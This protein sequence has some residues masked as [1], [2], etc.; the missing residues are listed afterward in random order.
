MK[1]SALPRAHPW[2]AVASSSCQSGLQPRGMT[3][4]GPSA[5]GEWERRGL[6]SGSSRRGS[7]C[8]C[9]VSLHFHTRGFIVVVV[10]RKIILPW[11][12]DFVRVKCKLRVSCNQNVSCSSLARGVVVVVRRLDAEEGTLSKKTW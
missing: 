1:P 12:S 6:A 9:L 8:A 11:C 2:L 5:G 3:F 4:G 7:S 10:M